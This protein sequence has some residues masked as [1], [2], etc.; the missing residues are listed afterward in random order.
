MPNYHETTV[1][2]TNTKL[3]KLK[4]AVKNKTR[5]ILRINKIFHD[6]ELPHEFILKQN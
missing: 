5:G 6:Q 3:N 2:L 1:K 4:S